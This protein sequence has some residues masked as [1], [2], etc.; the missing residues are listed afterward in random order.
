MPQSINFVNPWEALSRAV[1]GG[2]GPRKRSGG[3][4]AAVKPSLHLQSV[5]VPSRSG[6][7]P[8][9]DWRSR[10]I[11]C[12]AC[13][14]LT[15]LGLHAVG[16]AARCP[17]CGKEWPSLDAFPVEGFD[18]SARPCPPWHERRDRHGVCGIC[19]VRSKRAARDG[20]GGDQ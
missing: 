15:P 6:P 8:S 4:A 12:P 5:T 9:P 10:V 17:A 20:E 14:T 1:N 3:H 11:W 19:D 18:R 7:T 2:D 16:D 13:L